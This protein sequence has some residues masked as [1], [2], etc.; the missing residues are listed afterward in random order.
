MR[1]EALRRGSRTDFYLHA[2]GAQV[3]ER[4]DCLVVRTPGN[5][6]YYWGNCLILPAAPLNGELSHWLARFEAEIGALQ[7]ESK[8]VAIGIDAEPAGETLPSW[9]AAGFAIDRTTVV[10]LLPKHLPC[11]TPRAVRGE[12]RVRPLDLMHESEALIAL[13]CTDAGPFEPQGYRRYLQCQHERYLAMLRDQR[14]QWFGAFCDGTLAASCGL[15]RGDT[16]PGGTARFQ[17]VITHP[18][19]RRRGLCT[20]LVHAVS[21][22][23]FSQWR[24]RDCMM[25]ADPDDVAIGIYRSLGYSD[26]ERHWALQRNAPQDRAA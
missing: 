6:T 10:R 22:W 20:A 17:R 25:A 12:W 5:P 9:R 23:A 8:H 21:A 16:E 26:F 19:W 18:A 15:M 11:E 24:A 13:E 7:P 2:Y 3:V 4:D 1:I 14:L